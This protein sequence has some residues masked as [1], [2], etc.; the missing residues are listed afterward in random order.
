LRDPREPH[1]APDPIAARW[2]RSELTDEAFE[3]VDFYEARGGSWDFD[4]G[5]VG[6]SVGDWRPQPPGP[7]AACGS[8]STATLAA[9]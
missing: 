1:G 8:G 6:V 7:A 5:D 2:P 9:G 3:N 4:L